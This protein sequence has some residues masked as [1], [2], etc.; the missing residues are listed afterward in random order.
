LLLLLVAHFDG[1]LVQ[2]WIQSR[3]HDQ[4][5]LGRRARNETDQGLTAYQGFPSPVLGNEAE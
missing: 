4:A 3:I 1:G 2:V 5:G